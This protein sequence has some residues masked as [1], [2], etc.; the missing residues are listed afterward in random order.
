MSVA[1]RLLGG[2]MSR[3]SALQTGLSAAILAS[4]ARSPAWAVAPGDVR[5]TD[6]GARGI[7][8]AF[9]DT[10]A[11][12]NA[13]D[14]AAARGGGTVLF[15]AARDHYKVTMPLKLWP[16]VSLRGDGSY[17]E[18]RGYQP[19]AQL[20]FVGSFH[21]AF[22]ERLSFEPLSDF[23]AGSRIVRLGHEANAG[24]FRVGDQVLVASALSGHTG[25]FR[26]PHY[27]WLN[28]VVERD[29]PRL[30]L[31]EPIDVA[32]PCMIASLKGVSARF[33]VPLFFSSDC[34]IAG[35]KLTSPY[36]VTMDTAALNLRFH[37]NVVHARS[38]IYGNSFQNV[39]WSANKFYF[40]HLLNEQS[41]NSFNNRVIGNEFHYVGGTNMSDPRSQYFG[42]YFQEYAR[43]IEVV[44]N[45]AFMN[46]FRSNNFCI[47]LALAQNV[48]IRNLHFTGE[49]V[50]ALI[51]MGAQPESDFQ[52]SG[53]RVVD[54]VFD[55]GT[56]ARFIQVD[57]H[58]SPQWRDNAIE[59]C[60]FLG[61]ATARDGVRLLNLAG[62]F[63]F[64]DNRFPRVD[65]CYAMGH[66]SELSDHANVF[67]RRSDVR[68]RRLLTTGT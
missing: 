10:L 32:V 22:V 47:S 26:L 66:V 29:G 45:R 49:A 31:R 59:G 1:E 2:A 43:N 38:G 30:T 21:P 5:V 39:T 13:I 65:Q 6:F 60:T 9:D 11:I 68:C 3:R 12:Q 36:H 8:T 62:R 50:P 51:L 4:W 23:A 19:R 57:G 16:R 42:M 61:D 52:V 14:A 54:C 44:D 48:A 56:S 17:P 58:D 27:A 41:E 25:P 40:T 63:D 24:R 15:E 55:T 28:N 37:D 34:E 64:A 35:L 20:L 67:A 53:N 46:D 7:G 33:G 18:L